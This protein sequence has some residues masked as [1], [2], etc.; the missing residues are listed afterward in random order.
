MARRRAFQVP[1]WIAALVVCFW[2]K[3]LKFY[4]FKPLLPSFYCL[5]VRNPGYV[6][7]LG[8]YKQAKDVV[9]NFQK[10]VE[11]ENLSEGFYID[12]YAFEGFEKLKVKRQ[13]DKLN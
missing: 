7:E 11:G 2:C 5:L 13:L 1:F 9:D 6:A 8:E 4:H 12:E 3:V 10:G